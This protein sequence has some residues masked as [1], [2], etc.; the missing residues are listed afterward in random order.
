MRQLF[1]VHTGADEGPTFSMVVV[2][3]AM[4]M[5]S[6]FVW[7]SNTRLV[8]CQRLTSA[9]RRQTALAPGVCE[10]PGSGLGR[11]LP[12]PVDPVDSQST[13]FLH[14]TGQALKRARGP[15]AKAREEDDRFQQNK[16]A[17]SPYPLYKNKRLPAVSPGRL[18]FVF[19]WVDSKDW[20][21]LGSQSVGGIQANMG[22]SRIIQ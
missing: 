5:G 16:P 7:N 10:P 22:H 17:L 11:R 2:H 8:V 15:G 3:T 4:A 18:L 13:S 20:S 19:S 9:G 6:E 21:Q 14:S 1:T 12:V